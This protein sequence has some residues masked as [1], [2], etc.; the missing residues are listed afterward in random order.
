MNAVLVRTKTFEKDVRKYFEHGGSDRRLSAA[1]YALASGKE[2]PPWFR[3]HQLQGKLRQCRELHV[4]EDWL[5]VY[6]KDGKKLIVTCLWLVSHK[7]L[8]ERQRA[9]L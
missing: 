6:R 9:T 7:K 4:E 3:D 8:R 1:L 5:L 2:L